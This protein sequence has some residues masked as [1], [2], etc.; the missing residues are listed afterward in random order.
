MPISKP[1]WRGWIVFLRDSPDPSD[2]NL[3]SATLSGKR[4]ADFRFKRIT[5]NSM[6]SVWL[7]DLK[8]APDH[9][10]KCGEFQIHHTSGTGISNSSHFNFISKIDSNI[11]AHNSG[12]YSFRIKQKC[13]QTHGRE[14]RAVETFA[15]PAEAR[16]RPASF[17]RLATETNAGDVVGAVTL[18]DGE[19]TLC[20]DGSGRIT[21]ITEAV[22][23][24]A[25]SG[26]R[27][28]PRWIEGRRGLPADLV[29][30]RD[31]RCIGPLLPR[32]YPVATL[33]EA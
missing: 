22:W 3:K 30:T 10:D 4:R 6:I 29:F 11:S 19:I 14:I 7:M 23:S 13:R 28:L 27:A 25:V 33:H 24:I 15:R 32:R 1:I 18:H 20:L 17:C 12:G 8:F 26:Y 5:S 16:F 2:P 9:A 21:G 31:A